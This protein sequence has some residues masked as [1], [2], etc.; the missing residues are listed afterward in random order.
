MGGLRLDYTCRPRRSIRTPEGNWE[1]G[2]WDDKERSNLERHPST[3]QMEGSPNR[4][5]GW[6]GWV[7]HHGEGS[8][9]R[10]DT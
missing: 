10:G 6:G 4:W 5:E 3:I 2:G 9:S 7:D 1:E 8:M